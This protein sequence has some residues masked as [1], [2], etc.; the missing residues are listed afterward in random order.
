MAVGV[1]MHAPEMNADL[2]DKV[3]DELG[4][5]DQP[6]PDGFISHHAGPHPDGGFVVF[7]V[8][9]SPDDFGRFAQDRLMPAMARAVGGAPPE[10]EPK[11][12]P[13]HNQDHAAAPVGA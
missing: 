13:I 1:L 9:E 6:L 10:L 8:W 5:K 7:D 3:L 2:Y 11:F 4:W 12:V